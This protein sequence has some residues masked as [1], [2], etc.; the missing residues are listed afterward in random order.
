MTAAARIVLCL[1]GLAG[2]AGVALSAA[3]TH[4]AGG[5]MLATGARFL[6]VHAVAAVALLAVADRRGGLSARV[7]TIAAAAMLAGAALFCG[8]LAMRAVYGTKLLWGTAP[9]GGSIMI[10]SWL[11]VAV[12]P[13]LPNAAR[14]R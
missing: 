13:F 9:W 2:A 12:A 8:D 6:L 1:A 7:V 11:A 5:E 4:V 14:T 3:A 10:L